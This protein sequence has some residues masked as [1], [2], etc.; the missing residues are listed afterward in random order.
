[1]VTL[2]LNHTISHSIQLDDSCTDID[3]NYVDAPLTVRMVQWSPY[4]VKKP[5]VFNTPVCALCKKTNRTKSFCRKRH[6]HCQLP[7]CTVYVLLSAVKHTDPR[8]I[9]VTSSQ[10]VS[11]NKIDEIMGKNKKDGKPKIKDEPEI[12]GNN[13]SKDEIAVPTV[14][15]TGNEQQKFTDAL[16]IS[17]AQQEA[18]KQSE[19]KNLVEKEDNICNEKKSAE[20]K[21]LKIT[22][23]KEDDNPNIEKKCCDDLESAD[24][25]INASKG[26]KTEQIKEEEGEKERDNRNIE[27]KSCNDLESVD[28]DINASKG[29]K[30]E[31]IKEKEGEK[32]DDRNIEKKCCNDLESFDNDI[33]ASKGHKAEQI[34][35]KEGEKEDDRNIEKKCCND[36]ESFDNDINASKG[37]KA[38]Q[39]KEKEGEKEIEKEGEK[40][41]KNSLVKSDKEP[42]VE[43]ELAHVIK[44]EDACKEEKVIITIDCEDD[45]PIKENEEKGD[46][47]NDI[48]ES[49]TFL[50]KV[51]CKAITIHWLE[52]HVDRS[53]ILNTENRV[54]QKPVM[55]V[56]MVMNPAQYSR[57]C[58][59]MNASAF[60]ATYPHIYQ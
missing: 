58:A 52:L 10:T 5:F 13:I 51:S 40:E 21:E 55:N 46:D 44:K 41:R 9:V 3:G 16:V 15:Q 2:V 47:I 30:A 45:E 8:T 12:G 57:Y 35:E 36:F 43:I 24:N 34:K 33:N 37:H 22:E 54:F 26:H 31:H 50:V 1:M 32:E 17:V 48:A 28:N 53:K 38:E 59:Q 18:V 27:K 42:L 7:W 4:C 11:S 20:K 25:D 6:N 19:S 49:R 14:A 56:P 23:I 39:I 60:A 29:H